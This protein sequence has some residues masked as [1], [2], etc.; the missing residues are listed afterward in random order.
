[1][2]RT[3]IR[4]PL[5]VH[6][7]CAGDVTP[8]CHRL[9]RIF[10]EVPSLLFVAVLRVA[11]RPLR[12]PAG[13]PR[14]PPPQAPRL[15]RRARR[16]RRHAKNSNSMSRGSARPRATDA[17]PFSITGTSKTSLP[18]RWRHCALPSS[19]RSNL[20]VVPLTRAHARPSP[21]RGNGQYRGVH[22]PEL[23]RGVLRAE[24]VRANEVFVAAPLDSECARSEVCTECFGR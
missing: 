7:L 19:A 15:T 3:R 8:C 1:M 5:T 14:D 16:S 17:I 18:L 20:G 21:S 10:L 24:R 23:K 11:S 2:R 9:D 13:C 22:K 4:A 6:C 12:E